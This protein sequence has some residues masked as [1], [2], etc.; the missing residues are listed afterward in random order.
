MSSTRGLSDQNWSFRQIKRIDA[1]RAEFE[2]AWNERL[3]PAIEAVLADHADLPR[4]MLL[5]ELVRLERALKRR[6][7]G[8]VEIDDYLRRFPL[9]REAIERVWR[10]GAMTSHSGSS[11]TEALESWPSPADPQPRQLGRFRILNQLG[12]GGFGVVYLAHD[13]QIGGN[14]ALKVLHRRLLESPER[15]AQIRNEFLV[16]KKLD[17]PH[18]VK[19]LEIEEQ[20][21][22]LI[23]VQQWI[24]GSNLSDWRQQNRPTPRQVAELMI[25]VAQALA[26]LHEQG[27]THRDLKP[28]NILVDKDQRAHVAD[29]GLA[30]HE[31]EQRRHK[32]EIAGTRAYMSPEQVRRQAHL[33]DGQSDIWSVGVILYRLLTDRLPFGGP[34]PRRDSEEYGEYRRD[35]EQEIADHDPRP[36]CMICPGLSRKL[37]EICLRCL[38]KRKRHRYQTAHDLADDLRLYLE[39]SGDGPRTA[40]LERPLRVV[41]KGLR[42]FDAADAEFFLELLPGPRTSAG[43]PSSL[44]FWRARLSGTSGTDPIDAGVIYGPSGCGKSSLVKAGLLPILGDDCLPLVVEATAADTEARLLKAMRHAVPDLPASD[45]LVDVC[46]HVAERGAGGGRRILLV[47]DQFEQWLHSHPDVRRSPLLAGVRYCNGTRLQSL[48]LV[49]DDFWMPLARFMERFE[50]LLQENVNMAAVDLFDRDHARNILVAFGRAYGRLPGEG[51]LTDGQERFL[52]SAIESLAEE[53]RVICVRL[54]LFAEM[55]KDRPWTEKELAAVGGAKGVGASFL[56]QKFGRNAPAVYRPHCAAVRKV[57]DCLLPPFGSDLKGQMRTADELR[58]AAGYSTTRAFDQLIQI[59]NSDLKLLTPTA[60]DNPDSHPETADREPCG[61]QL[62]HDYL[63]PSIREWLT[64]ELGRTRA[65]RAQLRLRE[66]ADDWNRRPDPRRLPS[67]WETAQI[68]AGTKPASWT[69]SQA[70]MMRQARRWHVRRLSMYGLTLALALIGGTAWRQRQLQTQRRGVADAAVAQLMEKEIR[71]LVPVLRDMDATRDLWTDRLRR[72]ADRADASPAEKLRAELALVSHD[73]Q[74][75]PGLLELVLEADAET[76]HVVR[77]WLASAAPPAP[78]ELWGLARSPR[79]SGAAQ[80]RIAGLLAEFDPGPEEPWRAIA[81]PVAKALVTD[82]S[83]DANAWAE[84]LAPVRER[85]APSL[86]DLFLKGAATSAQRLAAAQ[87][88]SK[89]GSTELLCRLATDADATSLSLLMRPLLRDP[90]RAIRELRQAPRAA[91]PANWPGDRPQEPPPAELAARFAEAGG[92]LCAT[93]GWFSWLPLE[94]VD[95]LLSQSQ[96]AGYRPVSLRLVDAASGESDRVET[97]WVSGAFWRDG[98]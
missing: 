73:R 61:Y 1:L 12:E 48:F 80:L 32:G 86:S 50:I 70:R 33:V 66:R 29:F 91:V 93:H 87:L 17:H 6:D 34:P 72:M 37:Q 71:H 90:E 77:D 53:G 78:D 69:A 97:A 40:V 42:S 85:L 46:R 9:D 68:M 3:S 76:L 57:L 58:A 13:P 60:S 56:E 83:L 35:L 27:Y 63:V 25:P 19:T 41:P 16:G 4:S 14:V 43:L 65:S 20:G 26:Y 2:R 36:P 55:M 89:L 10:Q 38:E 5:F 84:L 49:R 15:R 67:L 59:L 31:D 94:R 28:A 11:P 18:L 62:T 54:A 30:L 95:R 24:E 79:Q 22:Q 45:S 98:V 96:A 44:N 39:K 8:P 23:I 81:P 92:A 7:G 21:E 64:T 52:E 51:E 82:F 75:L 88:L 74:R 47:F